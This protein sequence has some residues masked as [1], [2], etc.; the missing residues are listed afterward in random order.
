[1]PTRTL[2]I[3]NFCET[4]TIKP[5]TNKLIDT[6]WIQNNIKKILLE[7]KPDKLLILKYNSKLLSKS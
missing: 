3:K 1:M 6:K 4:L 7:N 2:F 5:P